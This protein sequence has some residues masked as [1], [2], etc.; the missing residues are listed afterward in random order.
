MSSIDRSIFPLSEEL[1]EGNRQR[2]VLRTL[3][4]MVIAGTA[5]VELVIP[6]VERLLSSNGAPVAPRLTSRQP[7]VGPYWD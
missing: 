1:I 5:D 6:Q 4:D 2:D 7:L 3:S